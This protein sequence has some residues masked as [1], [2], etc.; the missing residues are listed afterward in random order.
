MAPAAA[1]PRPAHRG[2]RRDD[3]G[4]QRRHEHAAP[5]PQLRHVRHRRRAGH[6]ARY[7][8]APDRRHR[9]HPG[10]LGPGRSHRESG[11]RDGHHPAS[12]TPCRESARALQLPAAQPGQRKIPGRPRPGRADQP[13]C[14]PVRHARGR[15]LAGRRH[16][17]AG[18][19]HRAGPEQPGGRVRA[20]RPGPSPAPQPGDYAA[21]L[22]PTRPAGDQQ[23]QRNAARYPRRDA[24]V[25]VGFHERAPVG[26]GRPVGGGPRP[27]VHRPGVGGR[28]LGDG[29][30]QDPR[31]RHAQRDRRDR[32][33]PPPGHDRQWP[34]RRRGRRAGRGGARLRRLARLRADT[35]ADHRAR[36][37]RGEPAVVGA[38]ARGRVRDRDVGT[39]LPPPSQ[40]DRP[41]TGSG[42]A[43]GPPRVAQA[44]APLRRARRHRVRGRR[45]VPS[46]HRRPGRGGG[47]RARRPRAR[48]CSCWLAWS[49]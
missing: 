9:H 3:L 24:H 26:N 11:H 21:G 5:E 2:G 29:P 25:S 49:R 13:G 20:R 22:L 8:P 15:P 39:R 41:G 38:R 28:L 16:Q 31:P 45:R 37:R 10:P 48:D 27:G 23:R 44:G 33:Q 42:R 43:I 7:R 6:A 34:G 36:G 12:A 47:P 14:G 19:R 35:A 1:H 40:D 17:L 30:A 46:V 18:D 4:R 32:T